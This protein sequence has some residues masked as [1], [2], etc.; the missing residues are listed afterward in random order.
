VIV[1]RLPMT[2]SF[3]HRI[4]Y[5]FRH[6]HDLFAVTQHVVSPARLSAPA[7]DGTWTAHPRLKA[8]AGIRRGGR[9][10]M[11][12][13][14]H[15]ILSWDEDEAPD[16]DEMIRTARSF[17]AAIGLAEHQAVMVGHDHNGKRH[18]HIVANAVHPATGRVA[19]RT[20][21]HYKAQAWALAYEQAQG[22]VRCRHRTAPRMDRAFTLAV[23]GKKKSGQ[24]LSRVEYE[25]QRRRKTADAEAKKRHKAEAW[26]RLIA[27][28]AGTAANIARPPDKQKTD[29]LPAPR[30]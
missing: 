10:C 14:S 6:G 23:T 18:V 7:M 13:V 26:T 4:D 27:Q 9:R 28:Q 12:P 22:R 11:K 5:L 15:D 17:L 16:F 29:N 30:P 1:A 24:R 21:D 20:N 3:K 2:S 25:K 19:D 8:A